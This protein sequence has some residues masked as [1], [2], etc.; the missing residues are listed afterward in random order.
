MKNFIK[1][2]APDSLATFEC[3]VCRE[4]VNSNEY[5]TFL[6]QDLPNNNLISIKESNEINLDEYIVNDLLL[7]RSGVETDGKVR[8]C[9]VCFNYLQKNK[10]PPLSIANDFQIGTAPP[11]LSN[12]TLPEKLLI[13]VYRPKIH[14][15]KLRSC[16][17][18]GTRQSGLKGNTITFPQDIV[19]IA[20]CLPASPDILADHLK[21]VFL[22]KSRP[23]REMLKKVL[24]VR[25]EKVFNAVKFLIVNH[26]LYADV[27]LSDVN[28]PV[29]DVPEQILRTLNEQDDL[30]DEDDNEHSTYTPQTDIDDIPDDTVLMNATGMIDMEGSSVHTSDQMDSAIQS[31]QGTLYVP[32]GSIPLSE[33]NNPELWIGAYPWLFPYGKGGPEITRKVTVSLKAYI[34]HVLLLADRK[35]ARDSALPFHAF[36]ILQKRD[37][38][39]H[40]SILVKRT[41][42]QSTAAQI[43]S[44]NQEAMDN[45]I[46][47]VQN[48]TPITDPNVRAL[49]KTLST[50]GAHIKGSPYQK[51]TYRREIFGLMIKYGTPVL[52]ITISPAAVHSP[53]FLQIAGHE[54][55]LSDIPPHIERARMVASDPV[56]AAIYFNTVID[57]FTKFILG[58]Q[59]P[60]GG[61]FGYP[62]AYYGMTEEQGTGTLHN[63]MLVWLQGFKSASKLK[64]DL[65]DAAFKDSLKIY[66]ENIIKQGFLGTDDF[67]EDLD[68]SEVSCKYPVQ[69][70]GNAEKF[71]EELNDDVNRLVKVANIHSCRATCFKNRSKNECRMGFPRDLVP[72]TTI[73]EGVIKLKRTSQLINNFNPIMMTAL[74]SNHDIKFIPSGKDGKNIAFYVTDYATKSQL[75]THQMVPLIVASKKRVDEANA[76]DSAVRRS[77]LT[78]TKCLN[79]ITTETEISGSHVCHFLLGHLDKKTSHSY[80]QLNLHSALRW[81]YKEIEQ[82][83]DANGSNSIDADTADTEV[84]NDDENN[85]VIKDDTMFHIS[86]GNNG[87]VLVNQIIDYVKRGNELAEMCL[88]EYCSKMYKAKFSLEDEEK[89]NLQKKNREKRNVG[90]PAQ[91]RFRYSNDHPQSET[92][93]QVLRVD[94]KDLVPSLSMLPPSRENNS[95]KF[96][97]CMLLL[98]KPFSCL[99]DLFDGNSWEDSY[100][101]TDFTSFDKYIENIEEMHIGLQEKS[102]NRRDDD[103]NDVNDETVVNEESDELMDTDAAQLTE[104][105]LD[106][107]TMNALNIIQRTGWLEESSLNIPPVQHSVGH[108]Q[109]S[110]IDNWKK[111]ILQQN[112]QKLDNESE[113]ENEAEDMQIDGPTFIEPTNQTNDIDVGFTVDT[114]DDLD[115]DEIASTI[116]QRYSL[117]MKQKVAFKNGIKNVIKRARQEETTQ[118]IGYVGGPGGTGKSQVIKAMVDFHK[119]IKVRHTLKLTAYTGTAAKHIGGNTTATLFS[120]NSK[121]KDKLEKRFENVETIIVDEVSMIGCRQLVK[122]SKKLTQAKHANP[123]LPFGGVDIIFFGDFIQFPPIKDAP[124]YSG[125]GDER[126]YAAKS[127]SDNNKQIGINL[128]KQLNHIILLDEQM[129]VTDKEYQGLLNRLRQGKCTD[130]DIDILNQRIVGQTVNVDKISSNPIISP[131]NKLV[132]EINSLFSL[133]HSKEK[134]VFVSKSQDLF[135]KK[136]EIL[137]RDLAHMIRN[138]PNTRTEG[139]PQELPLFIGM[140]VF[141]T[142]NI[143]TELG[144]TNGSTGIIKYIHFKRGEIIPDDAGYYHLRNTPDYIVVEVDDTSIKQ[145]NGLEPNHVP[146]FPVKGHFSVTYQGK[147]VSINRTHFPVVP[148]FSC[149]SHKS[150]GQTLSKAIVDLVPP[151][152]MRKIEINHAYVP[153]SRVRRLNDLTI[154]RPFDRSIL[155]AKVNDACAAMMKEYESR[156]LCKNL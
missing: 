141:L 53:I 91:P 17:G 8:C 66:L 100:D 70:S 41:G 110:H 23:T 152:G 59:Q 28:L 27:E 107:L 14:V 111:D 19:K 135:G 36:N 54:V 83:E 101:M 50:T 15:V 37:V 120:Y 93:W 113:D 44:L 60:S 105:E 52:W 82:H 56:S 74:R 77:H 142:K 112:R 149:T 137:P 26:P 63:H 75:S 108:R 73:E 143:A 85:D 138:F 51:K 95:D 81:L 58:Y 9:K 125:W 78:I 13:S 33:Y 6:C 61:N 117:N 29:D 124:L 146:I 114:S 30:N 147:Q 130:E 45:L 57:A 38:S 43:N 67:N 153:L 89:A 155:K 144:L 118:I 79:R 69:P 116:M 46:Q 88:Y 48:K 99:E 47:S 22:G 92:H 87:Y 97:K 55:D 106:E 25:R 96:V 94:E 84:A 34:K 156:D 72:E 32:H 150:Q 42:F 139:L 102:E 103:E 86:L 154:L 39:L 20:A 1:A 24:T 16:N 129:R 145:L 65:E 123:S 80:I 122:M 132:M 62:A 49:M 3:A 115:Y 140:P 10:L 90:R 68:V 148:R 128:W 109:T 4:S 31:L 64:E 151:T 35:F 18:P 119:E 98:F 134:Q 131:G 126:I 40:T 121:A 136:K 76:N 2:T 12:L 71:T 127:N 133:C 7:S 11:E 104:E 5:D 21:V